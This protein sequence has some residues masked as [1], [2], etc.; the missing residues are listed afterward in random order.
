[1]AQKP[2][3]RRL[4]ERVARDDRGA[5]TGR[6]RILKSG[7]VAAVSS[8]A[9]LGSVLGTASASDGNS[10]P[11]ELQK[12]ADQKHLKEAEPLLEELAAEDLIPR[13][14]PSVFPDAPLAHNESGSAVLG[15]GEWIVHTFVIRSGGSKLTVNDPEDEEP[16]AIY[17][18]D[19]DGPGE[20]VYFDQVKGTI[21]TTEMEYTQGVSTQ[22]CGSNCGGSTCSPAG[23]CWWEWRR[24]SEQCRNGFCHENC[25][26]GCDG[27]IW[28]GS[29]S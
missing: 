2:S 3:K 20:R 12:T 8:A 5:D 23:N 14:S 9:G 17:A 1:M 11:E 10:G 27:D 19:G 21:E 28:P 26:C 25:W 22:S 7:A 13:A 15:Y 29:T 6:R 16:Y 4:L 24:C 18:F